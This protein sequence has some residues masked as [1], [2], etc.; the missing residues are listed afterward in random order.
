MISF[1]PNRQG[2]VPGEPLPSHVNIKKQMWYR[3]HQ[4]PKFKENWH[5]REPVSKRKY[6]LTVCCLTRGL[7]DAE[8]LT[9]MW[10]WHKKHG[11]TFDEEDFWLNVYPQAAEYAYPHVMKHKADEYW[12]EIRR[13]AFDPNT[14]EHSK[15]RVAYYLMNSKQATAREIHEATGIPLK[16]VRNCLATLQDDGKVEMAEFGVY[17][18]V[19]SLHWDR[20]TIVTMPQGSYVED[21]EHP[22]MYSWGQ[23]INESDLDDDG[24]WRMKCYDFCRDQATKVIFDGD[25]Q[26]LTYFPNPGEVEWV[27]NQCGNVVENGTGLTFISLFPEFEPG[28]TVEQRNGNQLDFRRRNLFAVKREFR[29]A[30]VDE[31]VD[32]YS[33]LCAAAGC[34]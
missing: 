32:Y 26:F 8:M 9:V 29:P 4:D 30:S 6:H 2:A 34:P 31:D 18:A 14:R 28:Q 25:Q 27:V 5:K 1:P 13:I 11:L 24:T 23:T 33:I 17:R 12:K 7:T 21:D 3:L 19:Q 20:A 22:A 10:I 16:T 15:L